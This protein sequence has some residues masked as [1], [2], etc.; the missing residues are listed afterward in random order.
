MLLQVSKK[1][2]ACY[3]RAGVCGMHAA[4]ATDAAS[5]AAFQRIEASWL[6]LARAFEQAEREDRVRATAQLATGPLVFRCPQTGHEFDAGI[7]TSDEAL[8]GAW[9]GTVQAHCAHCGSAHAIPVRDGYIRQ[10]L[11]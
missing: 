5:R 9:A 2:S 3:E 7:E 10:I 6:N 11:G 1:V 8:A 4:R